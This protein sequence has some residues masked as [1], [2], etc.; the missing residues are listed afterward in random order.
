MKRPGN[1]LEIALHR[2]LANIQT[3]LFNK[4]QDRPCGYGANLSIQ[5]NL[6]QSVFLLKE[7]PLLYIWP[8]ARTTS[9]LPHRVPDLQITGRPV[10]AAG[11]EPL[12]IPLEG[13][14]VPIRPGMAGLPKG[15]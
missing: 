9:D 15:H 12:P 8:K 4:T 10:Q 11:T 2:D 13:L 3:Q 5:V 7:L 14:P 6:E 1:D